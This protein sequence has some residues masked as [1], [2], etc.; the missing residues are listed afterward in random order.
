MYL[1]CKLI[2]L[3]QF[4]AQRTVD[5]LSLIFVD[6]LFVFFHIYICIF[7]FFIVPVVPS[8]LEMT[9]FI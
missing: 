4:A 6:F 9:M 1:Q 8:L 5:F 2:E 7:F 3:I